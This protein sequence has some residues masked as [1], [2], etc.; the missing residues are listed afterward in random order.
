[1]VT[2]KLIPG[3]FLDRDGVICRTFIRNGKP[4]APRSLEE[5][6]LMPNSRR[7]V[8]QL[9]Q[10]GFIVVVVTNQPDIGNGFV[11][12][13]VINEMHQKLLEKTLVNDIIVCPHRQDYGCK[14][15]KPEPGMLFT[16]SEKYGIDLRKSFMVGDRASDIEAGEKAGCR[17]VFIDRHYS[18][19]PPPAPEAIVNSLQKAVKYILINH[20]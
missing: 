13:E 12:N 20:K 6:K 14:C 4:F 17:T 1:M 5:F 18:E 2:R 3:I 8:M 9:K 19:P 10:A 16:A 7:S 11:N 15:R